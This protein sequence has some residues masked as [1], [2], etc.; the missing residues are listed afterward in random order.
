MPSPHSQATDGWWKLVLSGLL[1][2][3]FGIAAVIFP[4]S[5]MFGRMLD[6]IFGDAKPLS[7]GITA[8]A[9]LLALAAVAAFDGLINLFGAGPADK[10]VARIRGVVGVA[11]AIA[12][13]FWPG[14]TA[15]MA[16]EL[17]GLWA[18]LIGILELAFAHDAAKDRALFV[19]A[20]IA[21]IA[22]GVGM[23]KWVFAGAVLVTAVVGVA[24]A[25]R[26]V[27]LILSGLHQ[28]TELATTGTR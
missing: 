1:A 14:I 15:F 6:L 9:A 27:T 20:A 11:L 23:M 28:R 4:G 10:T 16:V 5:I 25:A 17:I 21:L 8:V 2:F 18:I 19:T 3:A 26:G 24:S 22:I 12:A 13:V 7:G